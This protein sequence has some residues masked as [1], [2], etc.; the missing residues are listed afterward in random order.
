MYNREAAVLLVG[1]II[2]LSGAHSRS[3]RQKRRKLV[4]NKT[5]E[6]SISPIE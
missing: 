6:R 2:I 1:S 4:F 3:A 5:K